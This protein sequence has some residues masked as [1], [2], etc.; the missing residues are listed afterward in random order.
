MQ[1]FVGK[2]QARSDNQYKDQRSYD[3]DTS[4]DHKEGQSIFGRA[5]ECQGV[6]NYSWRRWKGENL[7]FYA[8]KEAQ[9]IQI[10]NRG[11]FKCSI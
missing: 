5:N 4:G 7:V 6:W 3:L 9:F 1:L 11:P 10:L 8:I 2:S